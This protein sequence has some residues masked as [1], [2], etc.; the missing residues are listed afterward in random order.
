MANIYRYPPIHSP[1]PL[2]TNLP[3]WTTT[4]YG[5]NAWDDETKPA[6]LSQDEP[7]MRQTT[8]RE[9]TNQPVHLAI[10]SQKGACHEYEP[11]GPP[12]ALRN[13]LTR[14]MTANHLLL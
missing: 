12:A 10:P 11:I 14:R 9:Y 8:C 13:L 2:W 3:A 4:C 1:H 6:V 7:V 5:A